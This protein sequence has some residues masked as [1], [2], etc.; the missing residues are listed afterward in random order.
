MLR[1]GC[2]GDCAAGNHIGLVGNVVGHAEPKDSYG[3]VIDC[4]GPCAPGANNLREHFGPAAYTGNFL[5]V[6]A[7]F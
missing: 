5:V 6:R 2:N 4:D 1:R 7:R 3:E